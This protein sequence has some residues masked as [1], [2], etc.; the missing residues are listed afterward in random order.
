MK[1]SDEAK[2]QRR[3]SDVHR[4]EVIVVGAG[5]A[6]LSMGYWL[7]KLQQ[8]RTTGRRDHR[9]QSPLLIGNRLFFRDASRQRGERKA[10]ITR[11]AFVSRSEPF[12]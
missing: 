5:Q 6:G 8:P 7:R 11:S 9:L 12:D 10:P 3:G 4:V 1:A 2:P